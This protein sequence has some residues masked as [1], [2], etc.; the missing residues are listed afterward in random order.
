[1]KR[2]RS[3]LLAP[4]R[5]GAAG[6][7]AL[8]GLAAAA[9]DVPPGTS[10]L[11]HESPPPF[12]GPSRTTLFV[13]AYLGGS[14][15]DDVTAVAMTDETFPRVVVVGGT[16][17][18]DFPTTD[19]TQV[20]T[21]APSGCAGCPH[22]AFV[23]RLRGPG[24]VVWSTV[25]GGPGFERATAV[26]FAADRDVFVGGSAASLPATAGTADPTFAGGGTPERGEEDGFVCRLDGATGAVEWCTFVGG[27]GSGGVTGLATDPTGSD[28]LVVFTTAA[29]EGLD[30]DPAYAPAFAGRHRAIAA[31]ADTVVLRL[32]GDGQSFVWAS[33]VGGSGDEGGVPSLA[34]DTS[35]VHVLTT[36]ASTDAPTPGGYLTTAPPGR[37]GYLASLSSDGATLRYATYLG[38]AGDD[39]TAAHGVV[40]TATNLGV[41]FVGLSTTS[42]DLPRGASGSA[43]GGGGT[44]GC[45]DGD[46]WLAALRPDLTGVNSMREATYLGGA[47]GD[48]LGGLAYTRP[49]GPLVAVGT[50]YSTDF[51]RALVELPYQDELG[52]APCT[53]TAGNRDGFIARF[54]LGGDIGLHVLWTS[55]Y[56]G[57]SDADGLVA[58]AAGMRDLYLAV[59]SS[60]SSDYPQAGELATTPRG[61]RDGV[62]SVPGYWGSATPPLDAGLDA[63]GAGGD[64]GSAVDDGAG[65]CCGASGAGASPLLALL[66]LW[67]LGA[68]GRGRARRAT[69]RDRRAAAGTG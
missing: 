59:G 66:V 53:T 32:A 67:A 19:G 46:A 23:T 13:S 12:D 38:G 33:H 69:S 3:L 56:V 65:G 9:C 47:H 30:V 50:T 6:L 2:P 34:V 51:P 7:A 39:V 11:A 10:A 43:Y 21:T 37:N 27:A 17:S 62:I 31:G 24:Q 45:G 26:A 16:G 14:G 40:A 57:G 52:G 63:T 58:A 49:N 8:A 61:G 64:G 1:M 4:H 22:D 42:A 55:T 18:P 25:I 36:T 29:G 44:P 68:A 28:V 60:A 15:D 54:G 5:V 48:A 20:D 41:V 35:S